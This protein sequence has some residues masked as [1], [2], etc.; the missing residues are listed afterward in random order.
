MRCKDVVSLGD[1]S[2]SLKSSA[3][4]S[5]GS[6]IYVSAAAIN[7]SNCEKMARWGARAYMK[8]QLIAHQG[9]QGPL[10]VLA[11]TRRCAY[12]RFVF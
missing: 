12:S 7:I 5:V 9:C 4:L 1:R 6:K 11:L 8:Q 3:Y 10:C 2:A